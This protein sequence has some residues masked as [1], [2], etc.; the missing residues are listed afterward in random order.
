MLLGSLSYLTGSEQ[1]VSGFAKAGYPQHLRI[2]LGL[3]KPAAAVVLLLPGLPLLKEWAYAGVTFAWVMAFISGWS[4]GEGPMAWSMPPLLLAVLANLV[5][6]Q[7]FQPSVDRPPRGTDPQLT[8]DGSSRFGPHN[9]PEEAGVMGRESKQG[10]TSCA[11]VRVLA[12]VAAV[13]SAAPLGVEAEADLPNQ[14]AQAPAEGRSGY[15]PVNGL[16]MYYDVQGSGPPL[17]LLHGAFGTAESWSTL[18][19][20]LAKS[21]QVIMPEQQGH[22]RTADR[23]APLTYEQMA[24]DTAALLKHLRVE[25]AD[26]FGYSDGGIVALGVAIRHPGLVR[27]LAV[28]GACTG[29]LK[30]VYEAE[31]YEQ[32]QSLPADFAPAVLK[33][34]YDRLAPDKTRWPVLVQ[35][36]K[37]VGRDFTGYSANDVKAIQAP[38]LVMFGDRDGVRLE[39]AVEMFRTIPSARLAIFPGED[40]FVLFTGPGK[41]LDALVP[42]LEAATIG[43][44]GQRP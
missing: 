37:A 12:A 13:A 33:D 29:R 17:V 23:E 6:D 5:R 15:A 3:A 7:A 4:S 32:Y 41:V 44:R 11:L 39:H 22:G 18:L 26:V 43:P 27:R 20:A 9:G 1:V 38:T 21:R 30:E 35:K 31:A 25:G 8:T 14:G 10:T 24:D 28:L 40:H 34:P 2:V 16:K 19:P 36:I 42:F